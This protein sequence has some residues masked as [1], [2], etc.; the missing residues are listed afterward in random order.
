MSASTIARLLNVPC[1]VRTPGAPTQDAYG[2]DVP[3]A[4]VDVATVCYPSTGQA[5][6]EAGTDR[7]QTTQQWTI[8]LPAGTAVETRSQVL[9]LGYTLEATHPPRA[10][11][12]ARTGDVDH[13][14]LVCR[15]VL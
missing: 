2:D 12:N 8:F 5:A 14:E 13:I 10:M 1:T 11:V 6:E 7:W 15:V 4:A 3:G 9:V